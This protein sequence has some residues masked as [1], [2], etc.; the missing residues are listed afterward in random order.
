MS[1]EP[2]QATLGEVEAALGPMLKAM[3]VSA[4]VLVT[5]RIITGFFHTQIPVKVEYEVQHSG[6]MDE[7]P[8][9]NLHITSGGVGISVPGTCGII[10]SL[11]KQALKKAS[12]KMEDC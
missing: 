2:R 5:P 10:G 4:K 11:R 1:E 6:L 3:G 8:E 9:V 7:E 12:E